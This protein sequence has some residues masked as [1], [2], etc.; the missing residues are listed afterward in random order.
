MAQHYLHSKESRNFARKLNGLNEGD[1][2]LWLA[3][4]RWGSD[5]KQGCPSCGEFRKHYRRAKTRRWRCAGCSHEFSVTSGTPFHGHK[6]SFADMVR[7]IAAFES[8]AKGKALLE[9]SRI[10]GCTP[11]TA[12]VFF[13]KI[14][15]WMVQSMDLRPL[16]G[17][18]HIDGGYFG[19]KPR[20]PNHRARMPKDA[21][22]IRH[23][24]KAPKD[25]KRPWI[26]AGMTYKNWCKRA[27][28]RV[29]ISLAE[30]A[31]ERMGSGRVMAFVCAGENEAEVAR[32][33]KRFVNPEARVMTDES[34]AYSHLSAIVSE[35][36]TV[37][38]AHEFSTSEGVSDNMCETFFSRF[39]R[40]EYGTLHGF[41]PQY[42]QDY[43]CEFAWR[44]NHRRHAQDERF[45]LLIEGLMT[46]GVSKWWVGYWQ[47]RHRRD[48]LGLNYFLDR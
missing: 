7:L 23:G 12:Q 15:E 45:R 31:G 25:L 8:G 22:A 48:E 39:R 13:G 44:E 34:T 9:A 30:S 20:K 17:T 32:L 38:H 5:H 27:R 14:R 37:S 33:V 42:L 43:A 19:G 21:L 47:G 10:V 28:K 36:Y 2:E 35:H 4:A 6:L 29:V 16:S 1:A 26:E 3:Q 41:R 18:V 11:K 24:K 40:S 46:S